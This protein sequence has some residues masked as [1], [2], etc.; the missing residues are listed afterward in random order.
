VSSAPQVRRKDKLM[1]DDEARAALERAHTGR[2]AT[3]GVDGFPYVT[4]LL[5]VLMDGDI[6][7]HNSQARGHLRSNVEHDERAC[8]E[9]DEAGEVFAYGRFECDS[10]IEY[11]SVIAFGRIAVV[12]DVATKTRFCE[13]LMRK[14]GPAD[15]GRPQGFFPRLDQITVYKIRLERLTGKHTPLPAVAE[16]WPEADHTKS[17]QAMAPDGSA[18]RG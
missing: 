12:G 3:V 10:S 1:T 16:Q 13:E 2:L 11:R 14:Y 5:Y 17:P 15:S 4:P 7:V 8:F 6:Y 9:V 18:T